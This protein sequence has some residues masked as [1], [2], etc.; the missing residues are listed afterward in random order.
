MGTDD[1]AERLRA[2]RTKAAAP[3]V[4]TSALAEPAK[5]STVGQR[6][7]RDIEGDAVEKLLAQSRDEIDVAREHGEL[8]S[9]HSSPLSRASSAPAPLDVGIE[10]KALA[11]LASEAV[12][13]ANAV[14]NGNRKVIAAAAKQQ[15]GT[16][17]A[18]KDRR[19][20]PVAKEWPHLVRPNSGQLGFDADQDDGAMASELAEAMGEMETTPFTE[21]SNVGP[22]KRAATSIP[23]AENNKEDDV[24]REAADLI[25]RFTALRSS[26]SCNVSTSSAASLSQG[27]PSA[28]TSSGL[29]RSLD[30]GHDGDDDDRM[31]ATIFPSAPSDAL[32]SLPEPS[33]PTLGPEH[34]DISADIDLSPFR[35]LVGK[36][37]NIQQRLANLGRNDEPSFPSTPGGGGGEE[38]E[39]TFCSLC[40]EDA[41]LT[42]SCPD[43]EYEGCAGDAY[44]SQC[45]VEAH[46][47]MS[48]DELRDHRTK[49]VPARRRQRG[50]KG[51]G[52]IGGRRRAMAA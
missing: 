16:D 49:D 8:T 27:M 37:L 22:S 15:A 21:S 31:T 12:S 9:G 39:T 38:D 42:C 35:R 14:L 47:S 30:D 3:K 4:A 32:P 23:P 24:E 44:C 7:A 10:G 46:G 28:A 40:A 33:H 13:D 6:V 17:G 43:D 36:D 51:M 26:A 18:A 1:L 50:A 2:L 11:N 41:S 5:P 45:W 48:K 29:G 19:L 20:I 34:N 52:G 25:A